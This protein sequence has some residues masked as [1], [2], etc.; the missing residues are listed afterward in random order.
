MKRNDRILLLGAAVGTALVMAG[1]G[2]SADEV[3]SVEAPAEPEPTA[4]QPEEVEPTASE[5][6]Q[7]EPTEA[8]PEEAALVLVNGRTTK[9]DRYAAHNL[10]TAYGEETATLYAL[11]GAA[12]KSAKTERTVEGLDDVTGKLRGFKANAMQQAAAEAIAQA[13]NVVAIV[14]TP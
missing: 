7:D 13:E 8:E 5:S 11:L 1:C 9:L 3:P 4:S 12:I 14:G 10:H 2:G 6:V